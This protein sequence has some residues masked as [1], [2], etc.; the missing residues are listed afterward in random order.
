MTTNTRSATAGTT[1]DHAITAD[2]DAAG[3]TNSIRAIDA[4]RTGSP[5]PSR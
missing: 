4:V 3:S 1:R 5:L 2:A